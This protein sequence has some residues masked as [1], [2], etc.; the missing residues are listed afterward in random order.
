[1]NNPYTILGVSPNASKED[2]KKAYKKLAMKHHP[3]KGGDPKKFQ[4]ITNAYD[5]LTNEKHDPNFNPFDEMDFFSHF[6]GNMKK[7]NQ[8]TSSSNKKILR[9]T[10]NIS[11]YDVYHG[12]NK[13]V[14]ISNE[15]RCDKCNRIC[16]QCNGSGIRT[17]QAMNNMGFTRIIQTR[18]I[19]CDA[20][21][22]GYVK[23]E[24]HNNNCVFCNNTCKI[25]T[26]KIID[27]IISPG[28]KDGKI[29]RYDN[30]IKDIIIEVQIHV[31]NIDNYIIENN[32][33]IYKHTITFIDALF[34][35]KFEIPHPSG[36]K[37]SVDT[38]NLNHIITNT[39]PLTIPH[40]GM[41]RDNVLQIVFTITYPKLNK[42]I[43]TVDK[44]KLKN[45][46][47]KYLI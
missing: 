19:P 4:Q 28:T 15:E 21:K 45:Q 2:V 43:S 8:H 1:M 24:L 11:M 44:D 14:N 41:T 27:I 9:K 29:Y 25:N 39:T 12:I 33:L 40:K 30:I 17:I 20:C 10:I 7:N 26:H 22:N 37:V 46:L 6:F 13:K 47:L 34:G 38:N 32:N 35:T 23:K 3:D 31:D 5:E 16:E 42:N 36:E 18:T